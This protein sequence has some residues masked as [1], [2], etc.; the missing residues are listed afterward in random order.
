MRHEVK[1][2]YSQ[3]SIIYSVSGRVATPGEK[4]H[5]LNF[6]ILTLGG[7]YSSVPLYDYSNEENWAY[8]LVPRDGFVF[9]VSV[10]AS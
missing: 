8:I 7:S 6:E 3:T 1:K 9:T 5:F 2:S 10:N 4:P